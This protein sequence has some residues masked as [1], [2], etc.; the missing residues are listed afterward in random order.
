MKRYN[1]VI[2]LLAC[3]SLM[4]CHVAAQEKHY[5]QTDFSKQDFQER[6]AKVFDAIGN[7]AISVIQGARGVGGFTVFRQSNEFYYLTGLETPH[8]YL[9]LDGRTR[10]ATLYPSASRRGARG[11]EGK[12]LSAEDVDLIKELTGID[13]VRG[14]EYLSLDLVNTGL[15]RPPAPVFIRL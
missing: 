2:L 3:F 6:R 5:Y 12:I 14:L 15:I 4:T 11:N 7:N 8:S 13:Q 9:L 1:V 10:R